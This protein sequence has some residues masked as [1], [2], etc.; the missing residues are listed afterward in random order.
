MNVL[1]Y[2][3]ETSEVSE[4]I[5]E[6]VEMIASKATTEIFTSIDDLSRRLRQPAN[7]ISIATLLVCN[8]EDLFELTSIRDLLSELP[9]IL[10]LPDREKNTT[11][12]G[13]IPK[14]RFFT[15]ADSDFMEVGTVLMKMLEDPK[16]KQI[17][18]EW[19][20]IWE[21]SPTT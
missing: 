9:V 2:I 14:P 8:R 17:E 15:Y 6:V 19:N 4:R 18:E 5:Y 21:K 20:N 16:R 13:H 10:I 12:M 1:F 7:C 11:A 3:P